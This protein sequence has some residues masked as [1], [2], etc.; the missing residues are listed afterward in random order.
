MI[1]IDTRSRE[2]IYQQLE[3]QIIKLINLGVYDINGPLPSVRSMACEIGVNPNT[4]AKAYKELEQ[5][6]VIYTVV[7]KGVY[8]S[9]NNTDRIKSLTKEQ[10]KAVLLELKGYGLKKEE[11]IEM[12]NDLWGG[13]NHD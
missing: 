9:D 2:P 12:I 6:Q 4:V 3:K 5:Q 13:D 8:V 7:G 10:L 11:V 1:S